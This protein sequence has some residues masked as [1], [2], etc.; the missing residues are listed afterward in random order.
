MCIVLTSS[1]EPL[2]K[3]HPDPRGKVDTILGSSIGDFAG[4][5]TPNDH[6]NMTLFLTFS[7]QASISWT[8]VMTFLY[9][10]PPGTVH[11]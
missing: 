3:N 6:R 10:C 2:L 9:M 5:S 7:G 8:S 4:F 11:H 1:A